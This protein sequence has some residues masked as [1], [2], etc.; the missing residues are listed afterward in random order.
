MKL[1]NL[2][3][4][5][6]GHVKLIDFGFSKLVQS[7]S[8]KVYTNCGTPG[9]IAPEVALISQRTSSGYDGRSADVWSFG[10][11]MCELLCGHSPFRRKTD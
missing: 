2:L 3:V 7:H 10:V 6:R 11:L 1:S 4:D 8:M 5:R 9:Y